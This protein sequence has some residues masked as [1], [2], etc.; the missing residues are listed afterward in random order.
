MQ[1]AAARAG[2]DGGEERRW[3]PSSPEL[4][5][6]LP[7]GQRLEAVGWVARRPSVAIRCFRLLNTTLADLQALGTVDACIRSLLAAAVRG[8]KNILVSGGQAVGKTTFVR[9]LT[10]EMSPDDRLGVIEDVFE[11]DLDLDEERHPDAIA[12]QARDSTAEGVAAVEIQ[13]LLRWG[14]RMHIDRLLVGEARGF[15]VVSMLLAM[16]QGWDGSIGTIHARTSQDALTRLVVYAQLGP[17]GGAMAPTAVML[18]GTAAPLVVHL[19][20][21]SGSPRRR[22]VSSIRE[23]TGVDE[24]GQVVSNELFAPG[25]DRRACPAY[26]PSQQTYDELVEA[27][28]DPRTLAVPGR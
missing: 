12:F 8:R 14:L 25:P 3:D 2:R 5:L 20:F 4:R 9:A 13:E 19:A 26:P 10:A 23:V 21:T 27:G 17:A 7:A 16:S 6:Q 18:T 1:E 24:A 15:E 22:V 11:L 28:F